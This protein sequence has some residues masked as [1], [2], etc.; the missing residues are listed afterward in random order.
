MLYDRIHGR[1]EGDAYSR[2]LA[3]STGGTIPDRGLYTVKA[4][5]GVKVGELEEEFVFESR[6]GEKFLLGAF[7]W[8][9]M[10]IGKD[11]VIV[12]SVSTEG[13]RVPFWRWDWYGRDLQ[14]A[15]HFGA[16]FRDLAG[17]HGGG[18]PV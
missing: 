16:L 17:R 3:V 7:A 18:P 9:I 15:L 5:N 4:E 2:M 10:S 13:A 1:V 8:K 6:V 14:T 11:D 12:R